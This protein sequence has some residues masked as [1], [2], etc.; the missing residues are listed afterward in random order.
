MFE[1]LEGLVFWHASV[2]DV[3]CFA[4]GVVFGVGMAKRSIFGPPRPRVGARWRA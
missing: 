4:L 1:F 3:V 2:R